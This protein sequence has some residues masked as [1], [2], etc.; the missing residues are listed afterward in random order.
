MSFIVDKLSLQKFLDSPKSGDR[1]EFV[2]GEII[3]KVSPKY[4]HANV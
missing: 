1:H 2:D 3:H 4:K